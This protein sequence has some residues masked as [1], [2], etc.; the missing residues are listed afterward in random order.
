MILCVS[1]KLPGLSEAGP[2]LENKAGGSSFCLLLPF[3]SSPC[4]P[5]PVWVAVKERVRKKK[6]AKGMI[7][8]EMNA[9]STYSNTS[10][11]CSRFL[12]GLLPGSIKANPWEA[13]V[14]RQQGLVAEQPQGL[15][16]NYCFVLKKK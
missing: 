8:K 2:F 4:T 6:N 16:S 10:G 15:Y 12:Q 13:R 1:E 14:G 3:I 7:L 5:A 11:L 9:H